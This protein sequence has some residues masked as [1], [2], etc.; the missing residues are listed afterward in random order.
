MFT[1]DLNIDWINLAPSRMETTSKT[2]ARDAIIDFMAG[3]NGRLQTIALRALLWV[4]STH[5]DLC[6]TLLNG[7]RCMCLRVVWVQVAL[8]TSTWVSRS[9]PSRSRCRPSP[10]STSIQTFP[11]SYFFCFF[12]FFCFV[13]L[14]P[15]MVPAFVY[16]NSHSFK[17]MCILFHDFPLSLRLNCLF[18]KRR[19]NYFWPCDLFLF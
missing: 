11:F 14:T 10:N 6:A 1:L 16:S 19:S 15:L 17:P 7:H 12:C 13:W 4:R 8:R 3:V 9:T 2:N 5:V 18:C